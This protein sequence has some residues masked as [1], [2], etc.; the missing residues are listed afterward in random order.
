MEGSGWCS[1]NRKTR[2]VQFSHIAC[3]RAFRLNRHFWGIARG[4]DGK[5]RELDES[6]TYIVPVAAERKRKRTDTSGEKVRAHA[7]DSLTQVRPK[8][9]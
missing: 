1:T 5:R 4:D 9:A 3:P 8:E 7:S 6:G 2:R